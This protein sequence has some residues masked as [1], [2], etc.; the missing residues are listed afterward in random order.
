MKTFL[1][2]LFISVAL[3]P[4]ASQN[5]AL[6]TVACRLPDSAENSG[7]EILRTGRS[8]PFPIPNITGCSYTNLQTVNLSWNMTQFAVLQWDSGENST[9]FG[10]SA[11]FSVAMRWPAENLQPYIEWYLTHILFFPT[12]ADATFEM[13]VWKD[14][15]LI[16]TQPV[17][18][19]VV[20]E[21]NEVELDTPVAIEA[22]HEYLIGFQF[23]SIS[24]EPAIGCDAGPAV[25]GYGDLINLAG[26]WEMLSSF[27][28]DFNWNIAAIVAS[29]IDT[30]AQQSEINSFT[31][32]R[33]DVQVAT[34]PPTVFGYTDILPAPEA[35]AYVVGAVY[36]T[37]SSYSQ[38]CQPAPISWVEVAPDELYIEV[39]SGEL[40]TDQF[41]ISNMGHA[42]SAA[43]YDLNVYYPITKQTK[44]AISQEWLSLST[45]SGIVAGQYA[46]TIYIEVES[47]GLDWGDY[48]AV[49]DIA[50]DAFNQQSFSVHVYLD[51]LV[52]LEEAPNQT[53]QIY[54]NPTGGYLHIDGDGRRKRITIY[55][56]SGLEVLD[57]QRQVPAIIDLSEQPAG[58]FFIRIE[59]TGRHFHKK[60][61]KY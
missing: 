29:D 52:D 3:M 47:E 24:N 30:P 19:F 17:E 45:E 39:I 46:D 34:L 50:T 53:I 8:C 27:G 14:F 55:N 37:C 56:A 33:D 31:V 11:T 9:S 38:T 12:S 26:E 20:D 43:A 4:A 13:R 6:N 60:V 58:V 5:P 1:L 15:D 48:F 54:P 42:G 10:A 25:A 32:Y 23:H 61:V 40:L 2:S 16:M 41:V 22:N 21:W 36:D 18:S 44:A 51:V 7:H 35:H 59:N 49:I 28:L 57:E